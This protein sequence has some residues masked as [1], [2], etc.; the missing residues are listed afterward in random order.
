MVAARSIWTSVAGGAVA[1]GKDFGTAVD[2]THLKSSDLGLL[3]NPD[4][5]EVRSFVSDLLREDVFTVRY[6]ETVSDERARTWARI[7]RLSSAGLFKNTVTAG[8]E[9]L[10]EA[11]ARYDAAI[12]V[13][14][15]LDHSLEVKLGVNFGLFCTTV[16]RLGSEEQRNK[17]LPG[18][19]SLDEFGCFA[20]TEL[21]HGSNVR[22]IETIATYDVKAQEFVLSTPSESA[23]KYWI[24]G[25]AE[26]ASLS[27]VF[28]QLIVRGKNY[29]IHAFVVRLRDKPHG[30]VSP[31]VH[32]EDCGAKAGLNGVDNGRI[33]F[34]NLRIPREDMLSGTS[35]VAPDGT[36][37]SD[38]AS[39]DERFGAALAALT[40]GRVGIALN[41]VNAAKIGLAIAVR[42]AYARRAFAERPGLAEVPLM[43]YTSHKLRLM[44]PLAKTYVFSLCAEDLRQLW[45]KCITDG[46]VSKQVH[47]QSAG[48]KAL[49]TWYMS[50]ALQAARECCGGQGYK[51]DNRICVLRADRDVM[52][53][54]EGAN[55]VMLQQ[56][57][58]ALLAEYA[59]SRKLLES[60][61]PDGRKS[62][63]NGLSATR[64]HG[65][66][67]LDPQFVRKAFRDR[68]LQ[69]VRALAMRMAELTKR[70][71]QQRS[72][73]EAWNMCLRLAAE[74]GTAHMERIMFDMHQRHIERAAE[75]FPGNSSSPSQV[76]AALQLCGELWAQ[77]VMDNDPSF[78]RLGCITTAQATAVH[79]GVLVLCNKVERI[80]RKL[81][82]GFEIA[83]HFLAPIAF[84]YVAHN[85]RAR[86]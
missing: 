75:R 47:V 52:L 74:A 43:S 76:V 58:K 69:L 38:L 26:S 63:S 70:G 8:S 82:D 72:G 49:F 57:A 56:V 35:S 1:P 36:Y 48:F 55:D 73:F 15:M 51:S 31:G 27:T 14:A 50:D 42:Y 53:T 64:S 86:L 22:G 21:G 30:T 45:Y 71:P 33:W 68:E 29:G 19:E 16:R 13:V 61:Q 3:L 20:L 34:D 85:S 66:P 7:E 46:V 78:L 17:Y 24:G 2:G 10:S 81:V 79:E 44:V 62:Q 23:Q 77:S 84:D 60:D 6:G 83:D 59:K 12:G 39:A 65:Y 11:V 25:A 40:G 28:A 37:T 4:Q 18:V 41:A 80:A 5:R 9:S 54:F 32:I 67:T